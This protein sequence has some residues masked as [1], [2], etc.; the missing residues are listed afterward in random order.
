MSLWSLVQPRFNIARLK[1]QL[2]NS[3]LR[4]Y[5]ASRGPSLT[6]SSWLLLVFTFSHNWPLND[7]IYTCYDATVFSKIKSISYKCG[8]RFSNFPRVD[9]THDALDVLHRLPRWQCSSLT[10]LFLAKREL[11]LVSYSWFSLD[12]K[13]LFVNFFDL[14]Y[15]FVPT[16]F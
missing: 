16:R 4:F 9:C 5:L 6:P 8:A 3:L 14:V 11:I 1:I 15:R 13:M 10:S 7:G 12:F 2:F